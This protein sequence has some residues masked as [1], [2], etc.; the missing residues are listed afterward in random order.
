L[1][2]LSPTCISTLRAKDKTDKAF[3]AISGFVLTKEILATFAFADSSEP[4][5]KETRKSKRSLA[6]VNPINYTNK[7]LRVSNYTRN[8]SKLI[9]R[10]F[11]EVIRNVKEFW[12]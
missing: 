2:H 11:C 10:N 9:S 4:S 6:E 1:R 8:W 12:P 3:F 5:V 7:R